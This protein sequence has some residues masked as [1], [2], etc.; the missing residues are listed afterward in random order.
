[1]KNENRTKLIGAHGRCSC[2]IGTYR[3]FWVAWL[4]GF[5]YILRDP[6][7]EVFLDRIT[8]SVSEV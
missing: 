7:R 5:F 6:G 4:R 2:T 1:M 8:V 3:Y